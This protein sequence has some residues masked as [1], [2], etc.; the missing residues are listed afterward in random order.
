MR[1]F[2]IALV[3]IIMLGCVSAS[4]TKLNNKEYQPVRPENVRIIV[5][6]DDLPENYEK[7]AMIKTKANYTVK[8][9]K[10]FKKA[11]KK[12]GELGANAILVQGMDE[13]GTGGKISSAFLGV[14]GNTKGDILAILIPQ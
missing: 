2:S 9:K 8:E 10:Q 6:E 5:D 7:V 12:A 11:R 1:Y 3:A 13:P 14:G 4:V